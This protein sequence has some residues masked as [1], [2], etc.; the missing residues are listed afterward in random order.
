M[1]SFLKIEAAC[2]NSVEPQRGLS[3]GYDFEILA[4]ISPMIHMDVQFE[5][6][7]THPHA[8]RHHRSCK[9]DDYDTCQFQPHDETRSFVFFISYQR[10]DVLT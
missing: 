6:R 8:T 2:R 1:S 7:L 4:S 9:Q 5:N 10:G 3:R